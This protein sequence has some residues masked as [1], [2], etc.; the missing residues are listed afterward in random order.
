MFT[1]RRNG[2]FDAQLIG[3]VHCGLTQGFNRFRYEVEI[4]VDNDGLDNQGFVIDNKAIQEY[5]DTTYRGRPT[6]RSCE[7]IARTACE[8]FKAMLGDRSK[9]CARV[10]I[11]VFGLPTAHIEYDWRSTTRRHSRMAFAS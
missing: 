11:R 7:A 5:F 9:H 2:E 8:D 3:S 10:C 4:S 6:T 1:I